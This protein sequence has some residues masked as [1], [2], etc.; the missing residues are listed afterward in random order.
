[1]PEAEL[2][3]RVTT[4]STTA[5]IR[6]QVS[7][8]VALSYLGGVVFHRTDSR[9]Q[10]PGFDGPPVPADDFLFG[11]LGALGLLLPS[12]RLDSVTYGAGPVVGFEA[13]IGYGE[14]FAI[15]PDLRMHGLPQTWL[16]RPA[17]AIGWAF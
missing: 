7:D 13:Y 17:V 3:T 8:T 10:F 14:H 11:E 1:V 12:F 6:Q 4:V 2:S 9:I 15:V 16:L 5:S